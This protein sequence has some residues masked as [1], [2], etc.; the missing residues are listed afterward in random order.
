MSVSKRPRA[1]PARGRLK[2]AAFYDLDGTLADLNLLHGTAFVMANLAEWSGRIRYLA[3][4]T[5]SLPRLYMAERRDRRVLNVMLFELYKGISRDRLEQLGEEYCER[6]LMKHMYQRGLGIIEANRTAGMTPVLVTGS[7][8]F[9]VAPLARRLGIDQ[10]A[11][12]RL[13]FSRGRA[14]GRMHEPVMAGAD[15]AIWCESF[16]AGHGIDLADCWGYADS[17]YDLPFLGALG[18][19]VAVNP[20]R[21]LLAAA[22]DRQWP[23]IHLRERSGAA[24]AMSDG[25]AAISPSRRASNGAPGE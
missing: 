13:V 16:A 1:R 12:N 3:S 17:Y 10:Y 7:P 20:D 18:H 22:R 14:T 5:A 25:W 23:V 11:A 9:I 19:P 2:A 8:D 24:D 15:K 6:I 21:R 4:L